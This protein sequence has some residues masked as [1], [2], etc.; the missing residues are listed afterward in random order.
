M[1]EA[2]TNN[3]TTG[4]KRM[5]SSHPV[6]AKK[7]AKRKD[8]DLRNYP[9]FSVFGIMTR[10][11]KLMSN[12]EKRKAGLIAIGI[13]VNSFVELLGLAA[14]LPIIAMVSSPE[15]IQENEYLKSAFNASSIIG[16]QT[17]RAFIIAS[18][19]G[20]IAGF[21]GKAIIAML[22]NLFQT[23]YSFAMGH[24]LSGLMWQFHFSQSLER[25]RSTE[26]GRVLSEINSWPLAIANSFVVGNIRFLN[27]CFIL[28]M[29]GI[30]LIAYEPIV[31]VSVAALLGIGG[32]IIRKATK[33][34]LESYSLIKNNLGPSIN[35]LITNAVRGFLEVM[36]FR[37]SNSI[38]TG[39]LKKT[40]ILYRINSN[41][42]IL[43]MA[44]AKLYEVL[45]VLA[46][47]FTIIYTQLSQN[48][49]DKP[50][51]LL[52]IMALSA[53]RVMP[54]MNR[55]N[56]HIMGMRSNYHILNTIESGLDEWKENPENP[57]NSNH[58]P[59]DKS[60]S[61]W[62]QA[63]I[64]IENLTVG[65]EALDQ[66]ILSNLNCTFAP[67][68]IHAI[69][70]PSGSGKST[71]VNTILGLHPPISGEIQVGSSLDDQAT[72]RHE[73]PVK[74]WL[75]NIGYLSQQP[76]LF[77]GSVRENLTMRVPNMTV[78]EEEVNRLIARLDLTD[79]LGDEPLEFELLEGG[80]NLSGGQQQRL[81][82][83]RALRIQRPVL[84]LDEATSAL[85]GLKRDAVFELLRKRA[86]SGTNVLLIT[87]DMSLADRCDTVLDL[88]D[89]NVQPVQRFN[90]TT[91]NEKT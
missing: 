87:H 65:Y 54:S 26:S 34:K 16:I 80:N 20:L 57:E 77:N 78:D 82:I 22:L 3:Q 74:A 5:K 52:V 7:P 27:E 17:E 37:A 59:V 47:A 55:L 44:P 49:N 6:P 61:C 58:V 70:G 64:E 23:R 53:Y 19:L 75:A 10:V 12:K 91:K 45:A 40:W 46:I 68:Q 31:L 50:M 76:F 1:P 13:V 18:A 81:A 86:D 8:Y 62:P 30:G 41:S 85:D 32:I 28:A 36:S 69:V 83:L 25:M 56:T 9:A 39:Y 2:K 60:K 15:M 88:G 33:K 11:W 89:D 63:S 4:R 79:C 38:K 43:K 35:T 72:L 90:R 29:I 48:P 84:I 73:V 71:L 21:F 42:Q 51:E 24:R 66:P 14:I 67:G